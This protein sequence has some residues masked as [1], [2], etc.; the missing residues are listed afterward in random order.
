MPTKYPL[1]ITPMECLP[2]VT[3]NSYKVVETNQ[4]VKWVAQLLLGNSLHLARVIEGL[5]SQAINMRNKTIDGVIKKLNEADVY[6]RDGWLFQ[7]ISWIALK[8][9]LH[10]QYGSGK[11]FM[12]A[13]HTAAA[14]HGMDGFALVID[15]MKM[16][17]YIVLCEDKCSDNAR[18][19]ITSQIYPEFIE[20][21][22]GYHDNRLITDIT[23]IIRGEDGGMLLKNVQDDIA[24]KKYWIYRIGVTRQ[25]EHDSLEG[26]KKLYK[27]YDK[28]VTGNSF[29]RSAAS[30]NFDDL[31]AWMDAFYKMVVKELESKKSKDV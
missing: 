25:K 28:K 18:N 24:D 31:R 9:T 21:E 16:I 27:D 10:T 17:K 30:V 19:I 8:I 22:D 15:E 13:P 4:L 5:D 14:Q 26:R 7:M 12:N 2:L 23:S 11:V 6:K 3:D 1:E 20:F 29:R